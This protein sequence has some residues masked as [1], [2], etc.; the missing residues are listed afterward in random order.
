[1]IAALCV[2]APAVAAEDLP[3]ECNTS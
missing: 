2:V 3:P 1:M